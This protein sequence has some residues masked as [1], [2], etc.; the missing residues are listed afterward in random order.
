[1]HPR[2]YSIVSSG[3]AKIGN[4]GR[5][6]EAL[7]KGDI[8]L[9]KIHAEQIALSYEKNRQYGA[10]KSLRNSLS[11]G[12]GSAKEESKQ[13]GTF[14][15]AGRTIPATVQESKHLERFDEL[16]LAPSV[17]VHI[18]AILDEWRYRNQLLG[19]GIKRRTNLLFYGPPGCGK[20]ATTRALAKKMGLP[21]Y[22][23]R[24]DALFG[25]YLGQTAVRMRELFDFSER[26][27]CILVLDEIDA[28]GKSRGNPM[29]VGELDRIVIALM[30]ELEHSNPKGLL[31]GTT[32]LSKHLDAALWRRFDHSVSF[33]QPTRKELLLFIKKRLNDF[34]LKTIK[35]SSPP[36]FGNYADADKWIM[37]LARKEVIDHAKKR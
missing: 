33:P 32:N 15:V 29:D 28:L 17:K 20:T 23:V 35:R 30:Q 2:A 18:D 22:I 11:T 12:I 31:I 4:L 14:L 13:Q 5:L 10:A 19:R 3:M 37:S 25:A 27:P 34:S 9:A 8:G 26:T 1:M 6:F 24:F 16:S 36:R 7:A 21:H